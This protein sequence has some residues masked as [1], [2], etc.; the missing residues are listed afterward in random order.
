MPSEKPTPD[1][2]I[3]VRLHQLEGFFHVALQEGFTRAA[4]RFPYPI[5]EPALH[6]QVRKL[7]RALEVKLLVKGP[8][9]RMVLTPPGR[10]LFRFV[11]PYF[12][13]LPGVL[14][15]VAGGEL[16]ELSVGTEPLYVADVVAP[17]LAAIR[18]RHPQV[19]LILHEL[20]PIELGAALD[21][22]RLDLVVAL[23][24][25]APP[26]VETLQLGEV[27]LELFVPAKHPLAKK[28]PPLKPSQLSELEVVVYAPGTV[29]RGWGDRAFADAGLNPVPVA[30]A[31]SAGAMRSLVRAGVAPAFLPALINGKRPRK[32]THPDGCVSFDLTSVL[33]KMSGLPGYGLWLPSPSEELE[34]LVAAAVELARA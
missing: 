30:S 20:E 21:E 13:R 29:A 10:A 26:G 14:R 6:Q 31:S 19:E 4:E 27:G 15:G 11:R 33:A 16:G 34:G 1:A 9:R 32:R 5:T 3:G 22:G 23:L 28:R 12:E 2:P 18:E 24:V 8:K 17:W 25:D 7:E